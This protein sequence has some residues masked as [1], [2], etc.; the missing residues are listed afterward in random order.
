ML[1]AEYG[2]DFCL[3]EILDYHSGKDDPNDKFVDA[4]STRKGE[5]TAL[6]LASEY[7]N[8]KC[9]R[10]LLQHGASPHLSSSN[11]M[12]PAHVRLQ[13]RER[14]ECR[15]HTCRTVAHNEALESVSGD[16]MTALKHAC[17]T[18][19]TEASAKSGKVW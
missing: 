16:Q 7:D 19:P 12:T 10:L 4:V 5:T 9:V 13:T 3:K 18:I 2:T 6:C 11:Q 15:V 1:A 14:G 17:P 8:T